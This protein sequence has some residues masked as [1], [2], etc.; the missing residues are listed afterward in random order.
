MTY[1][2][3][4]KLVEDPEIGEKVLGTNCGRSVI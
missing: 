4:I 3:F 1:L 2:L